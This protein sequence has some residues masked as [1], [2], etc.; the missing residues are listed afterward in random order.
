M[1]T[2]NQLAELQLLH[3]EYA[4]QSEQN[5]PDA[6]VFQLGDIVANVEANAKEGEQD[7]FNLVK[8]VLEAMHYTASN[9]VE[10]M[11]ERAEADFPR[12]FLEMTEEQRTASMKVRASFNLFK[13]AQNRA[14][15]K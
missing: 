13:S 8:S 10:E 12:R 3:N 4:E 7:L 6:P 1:F 9:S 15:L 11:V 5:Y 2:E 14:N